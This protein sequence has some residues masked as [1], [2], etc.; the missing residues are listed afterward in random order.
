MKY[1]PTCIHCWDDS[2]CRCGRTYAECNES[3]PFY[4]TRLFPEIE[5]TLDT[6]MLKRGGFNTGVEH[7]KKRAIEAAKIIIKRFYESQFD[8]TIDYLKLF[9]EN[10]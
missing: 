6:K 8:P 10:L 4:D 7:Q 5:E 9:I 3:C 1:N 2:T